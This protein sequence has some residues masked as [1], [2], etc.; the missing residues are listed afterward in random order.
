[1]GWHSKYYCETCRQITWHNNL[2]C[3]GCIAAMEAKKMA[4]R[5]IER[6]KQTTKE[7]TINPNQ[8]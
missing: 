5:S 6:V 1:M 4:D 2:G 7:K 3:N 8:P